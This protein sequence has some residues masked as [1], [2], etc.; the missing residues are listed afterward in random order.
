MELA[1][2]PARGGSVGLP[3]KNVR[4]LGDRPLI[5]WTIAA[6]KGS[7]LFERVV[8]STDSPQIAEAARAAGAD[9][10]FIR[11]AELA[12]DTA[13]SVSVVTHA[14]T[15]LKVEGAFALLQP[16]SP[17]RNASHIREAAEL[18]HTYSP[19]AVVGAVSSKP[20]AW[21][22]EL[23]VAQRMTRAVPGAE[24]N[25]RQDSPPLVQPNGALYVTDTA[26]FGAHGSLLPAESMA[27]LMGRIASIDIDDLDDF[28]LAEAVIAM[29]LQD[30]RA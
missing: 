14:L 27:L 28:R 7:G 22:Y 9:V 20:L 17:F 11:P 6:A 2:I 26:S 15:E 25:R 24:V 10:P 1:L 21:V 23:D 8:V 30:S 19:P 4:L 29:N 5:A 12:S 3:G 13:D 16:T 18:F